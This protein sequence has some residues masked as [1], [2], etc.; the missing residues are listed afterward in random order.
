MRCRDVHAGPKLVKILRFLNDLK[1]HSL[2]F[3]FAL[4]IQTVLQ[5]KVTLTKSLNSGNFCAFNT[6]GPFD[7]WK[8]LIWV[9]SFGE[10]LSDENSVSISWISQK[11]PLKR[12]CEFAQWK[13]ILQIVKH[14]I[15]V[16][17]ELSSWF[18]L[19]SV[20]CRLQTLWVADQQ[21]KMIHFK[22][23]NRTRR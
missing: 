2:C 8:Q 4:F 1:R 14:I 5:F 10:I 6:E 21:T 9:K 19:I 13:F 18:K 7:E 23:I 22:W 16:K 17:I 15:V 11:D 3:H 20:V 12:N